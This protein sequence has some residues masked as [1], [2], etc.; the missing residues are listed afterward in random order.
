[1]LS[2]RRFSSRALEAQPALRAA[3]GHE[4]LPLFELVR[5]RRF[6][7]DQY[8]AQLRANIEPIARIVSGPINGLDKREAHS[9]G[10]VIRMVEPSLNHGGKPMP[11][12]I[13]AN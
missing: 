13:S 2:Y 7:T 3:A 5:R 6:A 11:F 4:W 8:V 1:M 9:F 12:T 10:R